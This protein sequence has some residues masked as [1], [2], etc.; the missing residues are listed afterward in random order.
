MLVYLIC[1]RTL[2]GVC[3]CEISVS[4]SY[5]SIV[6]IYWV[7]VFDL[8][9]ARRWKAMKIFAMRLE[10]FYPPLD[11]LN[12]MCP[13]WRSLRSMEGSIFMILFLIFSVMIG[14][15]F[16]YCDKVHIYFWTMVEQ[17]TGSIICSFNVCIYW[18]RGC[19]DIYAFGEIF[20]LVY[21]FFPYILLFQ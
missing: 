7:L 5:W 8:E 3:N 9:L 16:L 14:V 11:I 2:L 20:F 18:T 10:N 21:V 13:P 12:I 19:G 1:H 4:C 17:E 6:M 15:T